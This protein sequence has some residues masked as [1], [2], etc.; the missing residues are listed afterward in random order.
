VK[1]IMSTIVLLLLLAF[2]LL[3]MPKA[4]SAESAVQD[5]ALTFLKEVIKL[6]MT[7]YNA[8]LTSNWVDYP[9]HWGGLAE[10]DVRYDLRGV[11]ESKL[12]ET[13]KFRENM[14]YSCSVDV[15]KGSP[16]FVQP[17]TNIVDEAKSLL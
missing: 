4:C 2:P 15:L 1:R 14:L 13:C 10:E 5:E 12:E 3:Q 17:P 8:T 7:K 11:D 16:I 9:P 6:D